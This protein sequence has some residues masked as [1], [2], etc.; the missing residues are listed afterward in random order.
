MVFILSRQQQA[1]HAAA[2][3]FKIGGG[4]AET[5]RCRKGVRVSR[6]EHARG[7][8]TCEFAVII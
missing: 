3:L 6:T 1:Y 7:G 5:F 4:D 8:A 2:L